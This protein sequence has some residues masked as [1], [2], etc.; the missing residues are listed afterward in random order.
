MQMTYWKSESE[1]LEEN[2]L[3]NTALYKNCITIIFSINLL[4]AYKE[5]NEETLNP[6]LKKRNSSTTFFRTFSNFE[7]KEIKKWTIFQHK[8]QCTDAESDED[9]NPQI[10]R[11][12]DCDNFLD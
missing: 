11:N 9:N 4:R 8:Q 10:C 12:L 5:Y 2:N 7:Y 3:E 1:E 6:S